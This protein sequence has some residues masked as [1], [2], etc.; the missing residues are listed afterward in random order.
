MTR[1]GQEVMELQQR[2]LGLQEELMQA[3]ACGDDDD[4]DNDDDDLAIC[5]FCRCNSQPRYDPP[6]TSRLKVLLRKNM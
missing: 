5:C 1:E 6:P 3:C 4:E 2:I